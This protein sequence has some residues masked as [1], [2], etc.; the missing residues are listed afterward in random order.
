MIQRER[1]AIFCVGLLHVLRGGHLLLYKFNPRDL[2]S[3]NYFTETFLVNKKGII[4]PIIEN[5]LCL[6]RQLLDNRTCFVCQKN[7]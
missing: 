4:S 5:L 2:N 6:K 7:K 1:I 3:I